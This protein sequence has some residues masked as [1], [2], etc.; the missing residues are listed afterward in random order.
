MFII[1]V[2]NTVEDFFNGIKIKNMLN[3]NRRKYPRVIYSATVNVKA[4]GAGKISYHG[5]IKNISVSGLALEIENELTAGA[6][7]IFEFYLPDKNIIKSK[8]KPV[9]E[10]RSKNSN[11]YG[12][13]FSS[14]GFFSK[15]KL[16]RFIEDK[17]R[18]MQG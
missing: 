3:E 11:F 14:I 16:K 15:P 9:W 18:E 17:L 1:A 13:E 10:L 8:G 4:A 6:G 12:I 7:Y 2:I 5:I